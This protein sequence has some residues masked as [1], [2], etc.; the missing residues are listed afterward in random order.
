MNAVP[1]EYVQ[2]DAAYVLG[3]LS[4]AERREYEE[5]LAGCP[6]CQAAISAASAACPAW[7]FSLVALVRP[8]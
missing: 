1:D 8:P 3:A 7:A 5:H 2:W 4:P 6:A